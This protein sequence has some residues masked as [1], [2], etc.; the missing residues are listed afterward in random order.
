MQV[1][2]SK[3]NS[4]NTYV[5]EN[6]TFDNTYVSFEGSSG[7][8]YEFN[9]KFV[10]CTFTGSL[11]NGGALVALDDYLYGTAEFENCTFDVTAKGNATA[12]IKADTYQDYVEPNTMDISL[13]NVT[14]TGTS[15]AGSLGFSYTPVPVSIKST[16]AVR[17]VESGDCNYT[18]DNVSVNYKGEK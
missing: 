16:D 3:D 10:N 6:C 5:F 18:T 7:K 13:K 14:F 12:A 11:G 1:F 2:A 8:S 9:V 4:K 17:V 15:T